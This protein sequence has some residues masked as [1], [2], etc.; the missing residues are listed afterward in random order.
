VGFDFLP[1]TA[2]VPRGDGANVK[3][4]K[5]SAQFSELLPAMPFA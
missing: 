2:G 4:F 3:L 5:V 1:Q